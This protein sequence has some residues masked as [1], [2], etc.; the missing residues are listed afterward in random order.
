MGGNSLMEEIKQTY[1]KMRGDPAKVKL[2]VTTQ[3]RDIF[4]KR[5]LQCGKFT[6]KNFCN[7]ACRNRHNYEKAKKCQLEI[8]NK[9]FKL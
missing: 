4:F 1:L 7:M 5:C 3:I 8:L 9:Q 6:I 2:I